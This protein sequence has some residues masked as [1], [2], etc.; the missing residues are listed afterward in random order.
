MLGDMAK[1]LTAI[2]IMKLVE[3]GKIALTDDIKNIYQNF[4]SN[5]DLMMMK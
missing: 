3:D 1:V 5:L 2:A 4:Q